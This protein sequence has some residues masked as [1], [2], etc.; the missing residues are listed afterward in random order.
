MFK[1]HIYT[2]ASPPPPPPTPQ[3]THQQPC[4]R[5]EGSCAHSGPGCLR[6]IRIHTSQPP[7]LFPNHT[8]AALLSFRRFMHALWSRMSSVREGYMKGPLA[9]KGWPVRC[10]C[11]CVCV[12]VRVLVCMCA[13][14]CACACEYV[15]AYVRACVCIYVCVYRCVCMCENGCKQRGTP[16]SRCCTLKVDS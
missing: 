12:C 10:T 15:C 4:C 1:A 8:P 16:Q 3:H 13:C 9:G 14:A 2:Q 5:L 11:V 7:P 6:H